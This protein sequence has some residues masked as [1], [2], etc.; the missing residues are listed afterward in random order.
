[1][2]WIIGTGVI[3]QEYAKVLKN[4]GKEFIV[5]GRSGRN[6]D[7]LKELGAVDVIS[8]GTD[9]YL[10]NN[11]TQPEKAIVAVNLIE[12]A[13]VTKLLISYGIKDILVEK[14]GFCNPTELPSVIEF[15]KQN[16]ARVFWA[17]NR[18][19][20]ASTL[21]AEKII[22]EDGGVKSFSFE[23]T[24]WGHVIEKM[25]KP[26]H[27]LENWFYANSSHVVDLAFF[28]GGQPKDMAC[29]TAGELIWHK[30]AVFAGSGVTVNGALFSYQANWAS[31]GRWGVEILTSKH[32]LY[33]RPMEKLQIQNIG[34]VA[35][36]DV[37]L[38][39]G[40]DKEFKPGFFLETKLFIEG[41]TSR[42][43]SIE[44]QEKHV[45]NAYKKMVA[46]N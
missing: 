20:L 27:D 19:C 13:N 2:I 5:V 31:P 4:L 9:K 42:L 35:L 10:A 24:E 33:L 11:P 29:F 41:N 46:N 37:E 38:E 23:F 43:C 7:T 16:N 45:E 1:M 18:R 39:D 32:R 30:P 6:A 15:A 22:A 17:Y 14:P 3:A 34:S 21:A 8:G 28:L 44:Q 36:S 40:L 25:D 26:K 12:L